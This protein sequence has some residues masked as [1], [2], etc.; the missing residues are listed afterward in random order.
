MKRLGACA[1][2]AAKDIEFKAIPRPRDGEQL[3][4]Y[5][6]YVWYRLEINMH[7]Q[8]KKAL[9]LPECEDRAKLFLNGHLIGTWGRG[10][11]AV[12]EPIQANFKSGK[13]VL[14]ALVDNLGRFNCTSRMGELKGL[15]GHVFHAE[16]LKL[17]PLKV[18]P[19]PELFT[20]RMIP[21]ALGHLAHL[22]KQPLWEVKIEIALKDVSPLHFSFTDPPNTAVLMCNERTVNFFE[23]LDANFGDVTLSGELRKG[24]NTIKLLLWGQVEPKDLQKIQ[25]HLLKENISHEASWSYRPWQMPLKKPAPTKPHLPCWLA[26]AW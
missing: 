25:I 2:V 19:A 24:K 5:Y 21:R 13:N 18:R 9:F 14:V 12:R 11:G 17:G 20:K 23:K 22:E 4:V 6:G 1:E 16:P 26:T 8:C 10:D 15:Y 7:R 3:G